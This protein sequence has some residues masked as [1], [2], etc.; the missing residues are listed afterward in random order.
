MSENK[1][2]V[3]DKVK[4]TLKDDSSWNEDVTELIGK[5]V[6]IKE[7]RDYNKYRICEDGG[8]YEWFEEDFELIE[9]DNDMRY[10]AGD[11]VIL[12]SDLELD[13]KY[14]G[15][16]FANSMNK[17]IGQVVK[18]K[19]I[20]D[21]DYILTDGTEFY[22]DE[23]ID[24]KATE[25]VNDK[26]KNKMKVRYEVGD[27]VVIREDLIPNES[28][29]D[30]DFDEDMC[31][32]M[33]QTL[34]I[35]D[36]DYQGD[37][38]VRECEEFY[39]NDEMIDHLITKE[40]QWGDVVH[41][42]IFDKLSITKDD[43]K[44]DSEIFIYVVDENGYYKKLSFSDIAYKK[45]AVRCDTLE[46]SKEYLQFLESFDVKRVVSN[47]K[48]TELCYYDTCE[49]VYYMVN[50]NDLSYIDL[51]DVLEL[52]L[53]IYDYITNSNVVNNKEDKECT[54]FNKSD[55]KSGHVIRTRDE[56]LYIFMKNEFGGE[57]YML[58]QKTK[59]HMEL[60]DYNEDLTFSCNNEL[61]IVE[62]HEPLATYAL[63]CV[64]DRVFDINKD[65]EYYFK[66]VY[67]REDPKEMT[68]KE[69]E[70]QLGHKVK[71][72]KETIE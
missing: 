26:E 43:F 24:H 17:N 35:V 38:T 20:W 42:H 36:V 39:F 18:I 47:S 72:V 69:I 52:D 37:Y 23:M 3:G 2:K 41:Q 65:I 70:K 40:L 22:T 46:K 49:D 11:R 61:D 44:K 4:I 7:C 15:Y 21:C 5:I 58:N 1:F 55:L 27:R 14:G 67:K 54:T 53:K 50:V 6:T 45:V 60:T 68:L 10:K 29:N 25:E 63:K 48:P 8:R 31:D 28:Y 51:S 30:L 59:G 34:T 9:E 66:L 16:Y 62:V 57:D 33:G 19:D 56:F 32:Y 12:R 13:K 71:L 64:G